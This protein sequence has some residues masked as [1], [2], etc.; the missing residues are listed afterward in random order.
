M[1]EYGS[2]INCMFLEAQ[3]LVKKQSSF[4]VFF[5]CPLSLFSNSSFHSKHLFV[6]NPLTTAKDNRLARTFW[7]ITRQLLQLERCSN[8]IRI[9]QV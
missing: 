2:D 3:S 6:M 4:K 7:V 8:P 9:Q 5:I 1:C